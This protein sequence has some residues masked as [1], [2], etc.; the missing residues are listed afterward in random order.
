MVFKEHSVSKTLGHF[1][2]KHFQNG[3]RFRRGDH[4]SELTYI[5]CLRWLHPSSTDS[6]LSPENQ[7]PSKECFSTTANRQQCYETNFPCSHTELEIPGTLVAECYGYDWN[8][9]HCRAQFMAIC[10]L[11]TPS[12][13]LDWTPSSKAIWK[14]GHFL[15]HNLWRQ[16]FYFL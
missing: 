7:P 15:M 4:Q 2:C 13:G 12:F 9:K 16:F 5:H 1:H 10:V 14:N 8:I 3:V 11:F 6:A